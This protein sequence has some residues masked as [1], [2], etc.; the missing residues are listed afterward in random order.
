MDTPKV[1]III[2]TFNEAHNLQRLLPSLTTQDY[3]SFEIII[4]DGWSTDHTRKIAKDFGCQVND[5]PARY[6]EIGKFVGVKNSSGR[7]VAFI[8]GDNEPAS[9]SWLSLMMKPLIENPKLAG[10]F[11]L[12]HPAKFSHF[13][14]YYMNRYYSLLGNDPISWYL[15]GLE[16]KQ[17]TGYQVFRFQS[18]TF[19]LDLALANGTIIN[20]NLLASFEWNDDIYPLMVLAARGYM[21]ACVYDTYMHHHHLTNFASFCRKYVTRARFRN[22]YRGDV[23]STRLRYRKLRLV[24]WILYSMTF[25]LPLQDIGLM[26]RRWP[27]KIWFI[28]PVAC[29]T[30]TLI[31]AS[32]NRVRTN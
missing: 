28:H 8:D 32:V 23:T 5:N 4:V 18:H 31:Y 6:A 19:P 17:N 12:Y 10:S 7:Y 3:P 16:H 20:R 27:D 14:K 11:C 2:P 26:Y 21:F 9:T 29:A 25:V 15:G 1:S 13:E 22:I 30:Q 24:E